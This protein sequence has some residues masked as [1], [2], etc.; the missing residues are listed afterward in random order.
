MGDFMDLTKPLVPS[1]G[2][3]YYLLA[4][5]SLCLEPVFESP[6]VTALQ[7]MVISCA[8]FTLFKIM[9]YVWP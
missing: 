6:T 5:A 8:R 2:L 9:I 7:A 1:S 4:R 3:R